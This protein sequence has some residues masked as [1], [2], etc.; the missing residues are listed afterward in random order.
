[1]KC[2]H[3]PQ[4]KLS[5]Y[6]KGVYYMSIKVFNSLPNLI[7]Y[8]VQNNKIFIGKLKMYH[9]NIYFIRY[10]IFETIVGRLRSWMCMMDTPYAVM[11]RCS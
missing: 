8:L 1:M 11:Y 10:T 2:L 4:V 3:I 6:N 5:V 9:C 7:T